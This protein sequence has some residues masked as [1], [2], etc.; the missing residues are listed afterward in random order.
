ML[1]SIKTICVGGLVAATM[2]SCELEQEVL[3]GVTQERLINEAPPELAEVLKQSA[4]SRLMGD[5]SWGGHGGLYSYQ[6]ITS[7]EIAIPV[8]GGDW[9]DGGTWVRAHR[10]TWNVDD[11]ELNGVWDIP[12]RVIAEANAL[13]QQF[14]GIEELAGEM[15]VLRAFC[16]LVLL[17]NFGGG[18][19]LII[20]TTTSANPPS[21]SREELFNFI[22]SSVL[23]NLDIL[24]RDNRRT[25]FN[26]WSAHM[27]LAKLYMNAEVYIGQPKWTEA[28]NVLDVIINQGPYSLST[29]Y[30]A[31]FASANANSVEN[32][33]TLP[34]DAN[35]AGGFNIHHMALHYE[36]QKTFDLV[37][38]PW[39]G[40]AA[41]EEFYNSYSD[42]DLRKNNFLVGP[43]FALDG[44]TR[45][46]DDVGFDGD[47]DGPEVNFT[48]QINQLQP[49]AYRQAG[50]RVN[51]F[52]IA[53]G[54]QPNLNNDFPVFRYA[55]VILLKA[56]VLLRQGDAAGGLQYVNMV[57][58]RAG[59]DPY[60]TLT[61][62]NL[63]EERGRE[64]F[65]EGWRRS[66]LIRFGRFGS[67]WW[68]KPTSPATR[69]V[70][71]V[72]LNKIQA[73]TSLR[74]NP[75]Y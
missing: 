1:R 20:E 55:D 8:K 57:R 69:Q 10:H 12:F 9:N 53:I 45:L 28:N 70:F 75:G 29:N 58:Q 42:D 38:Q 68:E 31:N 32:I 71:P 27:I 64:L 63:L 4:Y 5:G 22:E 62:D 73:N 21:S 30:F 66:D 34:Y 46:R 44:V 47:P 2:V 14:G 18:V 40:Y 24:T 23:E 74:Q 6:E 52:E 54:A 16:Y 56:E 50:A 26:Y 15:K 51:K 7:D 39:N 72:P 3:T 33:F 43:Q 65:V 11:G 36:S 60:T 19:P 25:N 13:I 61:L 17:D 49:N 35:N 37:D 41:L 67:P 59:V 48:P